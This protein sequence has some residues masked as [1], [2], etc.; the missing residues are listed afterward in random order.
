MSAV[1]TDEGI[2][3]EALNDKLDRD[4]NNLDT[5]TTNFDVVVDYQI[6][7]AANNYTWYRKYSSGWVE[8]G[9]LYIDNSGSGTIEY[10]VVFP[11]TMANNTYITNGFTDELAY[12]STSPNYPLFYSNLTTSGMTVKVSYRKANYRYHWEVKGMAAA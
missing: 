8:Q 12:D 6:P 9:G 5:S 4:A 10:N 2:I 7:T 1:N 3:L 11:V